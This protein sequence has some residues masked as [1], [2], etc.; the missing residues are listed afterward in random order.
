MRTLSSA[1]IGAWIT[2]LFAL[3]AAT[4]PSP[5]AAQ[6]GGG[7]PPVTY[8]IQIDGESF[9]VEGNEPPQ[10]VESTKK[11]GTTYK[12]AVRVAMVQRLR[13]NSVKLEYGMV[14]TA[15]DNEGKEVRT[16]RIVHDLGFSMEIR[17]FGQNL[18]AKLEDELLATL[19][20]DMVQSL[21]QR[22]VTALKQTPPKEKKFGAS[23]GKWLKIGYTDANGIA[24]SAIIFVLS[25]EKY[26]VSAVAEFQ[27]QYLEEVGPWMGNILASIRPK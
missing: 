14:A 9:L 22:K 16:V 24:R 1:R 26:T 4:G 11:R 13:L 10:T 20:K 23:N 27:D 19:T 5:A 15:H 18:G 25:G 21:T 17:D 3:W 12:L 6:P 2:S 8:E 7:T